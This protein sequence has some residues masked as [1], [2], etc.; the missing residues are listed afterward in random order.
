MACFS[1]PKCSS[2]DRNYLPAYWPL[3]VSASKRF[4]PNF[5]YMY[6]LCFPAK[7]EYNPDCTQL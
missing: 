6:C 4:N 3:A 1:S 5:A 7:V 2:E